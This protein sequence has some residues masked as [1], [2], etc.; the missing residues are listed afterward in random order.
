MPRQERIHEENVEI[1]GV[2]GNS[3]VGAIRQFYFSHAMYPDQTENSYHVTPNDI[4]RE[5]PF[6]PGGAAQ[7]DANKRVEK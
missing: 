3:Q 4:N 5:T 6:L 7:C 1:R 2:I